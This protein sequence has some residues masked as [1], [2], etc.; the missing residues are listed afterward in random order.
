LISIYNSRQTNC[1]IGVLELALEEDPTVSVSVPSDA[2]MEHNIRASRNFSWIST[3][4]IMRLLNQI[5]RNNTH[6]DGVLALSTSS[7]E[8]SWRLVELDQD[9]VVLGQ[10]QSNIPMLAMDEL[11]HALPSCE[12]VKEVADLLRAE[13]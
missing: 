13:G 3:F 1:S 9:P 12:A 4:I 5:S 2:C 10:M 11:L 7:P 6:L 8:S